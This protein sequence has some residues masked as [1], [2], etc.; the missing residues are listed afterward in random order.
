MGLGVDGMIGGNG[1]YVRTP[2]WGGR[3]A[4]TLFGDIGPSGITKAQT[5]VTDDVEDNG[6]AHAFRAL[7]LLGQQ[8]ATPR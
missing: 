8:A 1:S 4:E 3:D 2:A 6:L 7:G 5:L